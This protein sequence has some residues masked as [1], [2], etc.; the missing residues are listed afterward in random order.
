MPL[1]NHLEIKIFVINIF[2]IIENVSNSCVMHIHEVLSQLQ[3]DLK[4]AGEPIL[5]K[6]VLGFL[7]AFLLLQYVFKYMAI[8]GH[9]IALYPILKHNQPELLL[10]AM[11]TH[12]CQNVILK[13]LELIIG[14]VL[15]NFGIVTSTKSCKFFYVKV[16]SKIFLALYIL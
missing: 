14:V 12:L 10:P 5:S 4:V 15:C 9:I 3:V 2:I 1:L 11:Y 6:M 16:L 8:A 7:F 13:I